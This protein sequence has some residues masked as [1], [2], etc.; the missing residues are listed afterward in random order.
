MKTPKITIY[1]PEMLLTDNLN[2]GVKEELLLKQNF[3]IE[4][5]KDAKLKIKDKESHG[6]MGS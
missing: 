4:S 5:I 3:S 1:T 6:R 2:R